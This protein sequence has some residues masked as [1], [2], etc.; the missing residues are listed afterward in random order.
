MPSLSRS[1]RAPGGRGFSAEAGGQAAGSW[2]APRLIL[3]SPLQ[4][5][6]SGQ[7]ISTPPLTPEPTFIMCQIRMVLTFRIVFK[8][9]KINH[10][11]HLWK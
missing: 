5:S 2:A 9:L 3:A 7:I 10:E 11:V 1:S 6:D 8:V 4:L